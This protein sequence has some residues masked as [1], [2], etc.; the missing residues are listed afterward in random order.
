MYNVNFY[1]RSKECRMKREWAIE[2]GSN[3]EPFGVLGSLAS[4]LFQI[5]RYISVC[6]ANNMRETHKS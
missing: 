3:V 2:N 5:E 6:R 4:P 1:P